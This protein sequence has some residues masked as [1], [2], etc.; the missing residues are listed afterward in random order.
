MSIYFG[1]FLL[2][3]VNVGYLMSIIDGEK[4]L[5]EIQACLTRDNCY[6]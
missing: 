6:E 4:G 3:F 1:V 5:K 2:L